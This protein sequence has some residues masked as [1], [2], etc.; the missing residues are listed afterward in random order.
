MAHALLANGATAL[1]VVV[2]AVVALEDDPLFNA[3]RGAVLT[4]DGQAELDAAV[5]EGTQR[6]AGAVAACRTVRNPVQLAA[7]IMSDTSHV[8]LVGEGA[9]ALAGELGLECVAPSYFVT[10]ER[11]AQLERALSTGALHLDHETERDAYGT[12]GAVACDADGQLA[13]ATSTGGMV[14]QLPGRVGD[15]PVIGAGTFAWNA[16]CAV[17]GTGHGEPFIRLGV[18]SRVSARM[19]LLGEAVDLASRRVLDDLAEVNGRGGMIAVDANGRV[20]MPFNTGGM[21]RGYQLEGGAPVIAI[22]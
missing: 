16:T 7:R 12:V 6:R 9:D 14:N 17:S 15:T 2:A 22:W 1:D 18:G 5:M 11:R 4:R 10:D 20:A 8:M 19:E 21:F 3:G 13:A